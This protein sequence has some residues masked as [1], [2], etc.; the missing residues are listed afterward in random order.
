[1]IPKFSVKKPYTVLVAVVLVLILGVVSFTKM[2]PDLLPSMDLP[3]A[4]IMTTYAGASP[5]A[6]ETTVTKPIEQSMATISNIENV[7]SVSQENMSLVILE[8]SSDANMDTAMIDIRESLDLVTGYFSD[9]IGNPIIMKL[10]PDMMPVLVSAV[11]ADDMDLTEISSIVDNEVVPA[12]EA[13]EGVGSVSASGLLEESVNVVINQDKIDK[14]NKKI[15]KAT[16]A[17]FT[18]AEEKLDD[19]KSELESGK[20]QL[21]SQSSKLNETLAEANNA[22][23]NGKIDLATKKSELNQSLTTLKSQITQLESTI[24]ELKTQKSSLQSAIKSLKSTKKNRDELVSNQSKLESQIEEVKKNDALSEEEKQAALTPLESSL[25]SVKAGIEAVDTGLDA[26]GIKGSELSSSISEMETNLSTINTNL[27]ELE[28]NLKEAKAGKKQI[29]EGLEQLEEGQDTLDEQM[30]QMDSQKSSAQQSLSSASAEIVAG[31]T[32]LSASEQEL[33]EAKESAIEQASLEGKITADTIKSILTAQNFSMPAGYI[34]EDNTDYLVRVGDK[35][36]DTDQVEDLVLMDLGLDGLDPIT[37]GDVA[38]VAVVDNSDEIYAKVNGN[39]S[40]ILVVQKQNNYATADVSERVQ[41]KF[42]ELVKKTDG[43]HFTNL[44]DQ[45]VYINLIVDSVL[46]NIWM[47]ALLA[48]LILFVFLKSIKPTFIVGISIPISVVLAIV[49]MYF[50]GITL[51]MISLSGLALGVGMLVDNS[52]VVIENIFRLKKEGMPIKEA[53]VKG[54]NQVFGAICAST[55]TTVSVFLPIVFVEGL[56]R[57][58]MQDLALTVGYSLLASLLVAITA[59]PAMAAKTMGEMKERKDVILPK[60]QTVYG[61]SMEKFLK[62]REIV[63]VA[64]IGLMILTGYLAIQKGSSLM[65]SM[66]STQMSATLTMPSGSVLAD[67]K[68]MANE[69]SERI[70]SVEGVET[71]GA[72]SGG[73]SI[74]SMFGGSS[75]DGSVSMYILLDEN[76]SRTNKEIQKD[77]EDKTKDLD[78]ELSISTSTMDLSSLGESGISVQIKGKDLDEL[79]TIADDVAEIVKETE[80]TKE[81]DNGQEETTKELRVSVKKSKAMAYGLTVA[82]VYQSI[83]EKLSE[84]TDAT[85]LDTGDKEYTVTIKDGEGDSITAENLK[86]FQVTGTKDGKEKKVRLSKIATITEAVGPDSITRDS[87]SRYMTVTADVEDGY[88]VTLVSQEIEKKLE[89]YEM[90]TGYS[91]TMG[92]EY[93]TVQENMSQVLLMLVLA[94]AFMYLIMVAQFQSLKSPFIILFTIPLAFT[95]GFIAL[96]LCGMDVSIIAM[97]GFIML[98]GIIVNNGIVLVDYINQ[99]REEGMEKREAII[100]AGQTRMRPII[101]TALTT[102][103]GLVFMAAGVGDGSEMMQPMAVVTIGGLIYGT[104]L[105]LIVIPCVYDVFHPDHK[106]RKKLVWKKKKSDG[107]EEEFPKL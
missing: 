37:L 44:M 23:I 57:T 8:F 10:N 85:T 55:L 45:G 49:L 51:N 43:L 73:S 9:S 18:E 107:K 53:A 13:V 75:D 48:I 33:E 88:N 62:F 47:G 54:A 17:S 20:S 80:G 101:M 91:Y 69:V 105:T 81:V 28:S 78:C 74:S 102:I 14:V 5:E 3:Y 12:I 27:K 70:Q 89:Q 93:E 32:Q 35:I 11:D 30:T 26:Q 77:I 29:E 67:T 41:D 68:E 82:Q 16:K 98:S 6:V 21:E 60:L 4:I 97:F 71:I 100:T 83:S 15:K 96:L 46:N 56:T 72:M 84:G 58:L 90:P 7:S 36:E 94:I 99:L 86:D 31:E 52:I 22:L 92:G 87:Q 76:T 38:D 59:V 24:S 40:I 95:G 65:P 1:M 63:I 42:D 39:D 19:A 34:T 25:E 50:S 103:L 61:K 66:E 79:A 104:L 64:A 2:T 106:N